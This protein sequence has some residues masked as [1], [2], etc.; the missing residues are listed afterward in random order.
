MLIRALHGRLVV[1][2]G[3]EIDEVV[4]DDQRF[5]LILH[6]KVEGVVTLFVLDSNFPLHHLVMPVGRRAE[7]PNPI[8]KDNGLLVR[9]IDIVVVSKDNRILWVETRAIPRRHDG[10]RRRR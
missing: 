10:W 1:V 8:L 3:R 2:V 4:D 5:L 9:V 7:V 6:L